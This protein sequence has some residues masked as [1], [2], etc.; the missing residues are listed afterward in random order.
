[1]TNERT[2]RVTQNDES[3]VF[4][5]Y[6]SYQVV[7]TEIKD[8]FL[9][10]E[11]VF[12]KEEKNRVRYAFKL[13]A[14]NSNEGLL[15][16]SYGVFLMATLMDRFDQNN[17]FTDDQKEKFKNSI[18]ALLEYVEEHGY[19]ATPFSTEEIN[20]KLFGNTKKNAFIE[21]LTWSLSAFLYAKRLQ[22]IDK[23]FGLEEYT[24]RITHKIAEAMGLLVE[25]AISTS[26]DGRV[27]L[28]YVK[29]CTSYMGW[30]S[31]TGCTE[32]SL[33]FTHSVCETYGDIEDTM[34]GNKILGIEEDKELKKAV[35]DAYQ[36]IKY[37][38]V[39]QDVGLGK[40]VNIVDRF[41]DICSITA[42]NVFQK[43]E[44]SLGR[45]FFYSNGAEVP[46]NDQ[47]AC[48][49]QTPVLL[50][51]LYVVLIAVY[52]NYHKEVEKVSTSK[53]NDA[54]NDFCLKI[55]NA[56]NLVHETYLALQKKGKAGIVNREYATFA[57]AH[58]N[59]NIARM[60]ADERINVAILETLI[61]KA[62]AM[63]IT[64]VTMCPEKEIGE[65]LE[66]V[67]Q[68]RAD[69]AWI[70]SKYGHDLQQTERSISAIKEFYDYYDN[71]QKVY[72]QCD[73]KNNDVAEQETRK[74]LENERKAMA[75][76][77]EKER[78]ELEE[79]FAKEKAEAIEQTKA[80][81]KIDGVVREI[82]REEMEAQF[83]DV[84][85]KY[86]RDV[87]LDNTKE[88]SK[89][90]LSPEARVFKNAISELLLS[91]FL[92]FNSYASPEGKG[93]KE[94]N[95]GQ[96]FDLIKFD[97]YEFAREWANQLF[98]KNEPGTSIPVSVLKRIIEEDKQ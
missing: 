51:Q 75:E 80:K 3:V 65:V 62:R 85:S 37:K 69:D 72:A 33:Y 29:D 31:V 36:I 8:D 73:A 1:M 78:I 71:F 95:E 46:S 84:L 91:Y 89:S 49:L 24:D 77:A 74:W 15:G 32:A 25:S 28:G 63:I 83:A 43:Y 13:S 96:L 23:D 58:P 87:A 41:C 64:Y 12:E 70:W 39:N 52:A 17:M 45:K 44:K 18:I 21:S 92:P 10:S 60:L 94:W 2:L 97:V 11:L 7:G 4:P 47:I 90:E 19:D 55:K 14:T 93:A 40:Y 57:E 20:K 42:R 6:R 38:V 81:Y 27:Q 76:K 16:L 48:S 86:C 30:G 34:T 26:D 59:P 22:K 5:L 61:I 35:N 68:T 50:N 53:K 82:I 67:G 98:K 88:P 54:Y 79:R 66:I 56:V 9:N